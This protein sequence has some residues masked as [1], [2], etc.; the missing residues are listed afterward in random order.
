MQLRPE[1]MFILIW[2][3]AKYSITY[4]EIKHLTCRVYENVFHFVHLAEF[5]TFFISPSF[6]NESS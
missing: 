6:L 2:R 4:S 5:K 3:V 1:S